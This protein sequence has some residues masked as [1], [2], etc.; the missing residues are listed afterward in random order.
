VGFRRRLVESPRARRCRAPY[1]WWHRLSSL[2][3]T[4][5]GTPRLRRA[6]RVVPLRTL[7]PAT[8]RVPIGG[9][10]MR[11][12]PMAAHRGVWALARF[13][14]RKQLPGEKE[15][16]VLAGDQ[17]RRAVPKRRAPSAL[18]SF[19]KAFFSFSPALGTHGAQKRAKAHTH[20]PPR[21]RRGGFLHSL[22]L[23]GAPFRWHRL[24]SLWSGRRAASPLQDWAVV[25]RW[26]RAVRARGPAPT[27]LADA[28]SI[29]CRGRPL[30]L[31]DFGSC[32]SPIL[33]SAPPQR[34]SRTLRCMTTVDGAS[35][36]ASMS[37]PLGQK[38]GWN[39]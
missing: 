8:Y 35:R 2:C 31:A 13:L 1:R 14:H 10:S 29:H 32:P 28:D 19:G 21:R 12:H 26:L 11:K 38:P 5:G 7:I 25:R 20:R 33:L 27:D 23:S 22:R 24:S 15:K 16:N 6:R 30:C 36:P 39:N 17:S 37:F 9:T 4:R 3:P 18:R 34:S